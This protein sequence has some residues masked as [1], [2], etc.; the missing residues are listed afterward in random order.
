MGRI[1]KEVIYITTCSCLFL[2]LILVIISG[3]V[4]NNKRT[5]ELEQISQESN[6][7]VT[8]VSD[9]QDENTII[10]Q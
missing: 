10:N 2:F 4:Q 8:S 3:T 6:Y 5:H 1:S 7:S 9:K